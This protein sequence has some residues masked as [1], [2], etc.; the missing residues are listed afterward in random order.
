MTLGP[1]L[2]PEGSRR[3]FEPSRKSRKLGIYVTGGSAGDLVHCILLDKSEIYPEPQCPSYG[4]G[5]MIKKNV[6]S[7]VIDNVGYICPFS[8]VKQIGKMPF[9]IKKKKFC[10]F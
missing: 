9:L 8:Q 10:L 3:H 5:A 1:S 4:L 7:A 2:C 6:S